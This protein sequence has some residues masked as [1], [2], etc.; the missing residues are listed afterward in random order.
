[1]T[2]LFKALKILYI[3]QCKSAVAP[4]NSSLIAE[5]ITRATK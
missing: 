3:D 1:L 2:Y 5:T 4:A